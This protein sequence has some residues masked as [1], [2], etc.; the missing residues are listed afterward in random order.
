MP[1]KAPT[2]GASAITTPSF[3][4]YGADDFSRRALPPAADVGFLRPGQVPEDRAL[5]SLGT[6][7]QD[8]TGWPLFGRKIASCRLDVVHKYLEALREFRQGLIASTM[9]SE[10]TVVSCW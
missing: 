2:P 5:T 8:D 3:N 10:R 9:I 6:P 1:S 7:H 4:R